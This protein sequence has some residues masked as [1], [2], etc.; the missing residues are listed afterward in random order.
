MVW[1][2]IYAADA[3]LQTWYLIFLT[4]IIEALTLK[5]YAEVN[6]SYSLL[7]SVI[8]NGFSA[9]IGT[10]IMIPGM[11]I[12]HIIVD[13]FIYQF[14]SNQIGTFHPIHWLPLLRLW[15]L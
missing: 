15:L 7:T 10:I 8:A 12:Y 14:I 1:P 13:T 6:F 9:I 5:Y 3:L 2:A 11:L 4:I